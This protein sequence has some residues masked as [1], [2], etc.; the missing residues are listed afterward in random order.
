MRR[1][2]ASFQA[3]LASLSEQRS[4]A[5]LSSLGI[6]VGSVAILLLVSIAKGVQDDI[7]KEVEGLGVNLLI[8][9]P[10]RFEDNSML[11]PGLIGISHL[12]REDI[13]RIRGLSGVREAVPFS[14]VG[15]GLASGERR[16]P[17][18]M[19]VATQPEWF[20]MR[21][22]AFRE[23]RGI[24]PEERQAYVCVLGSL[25]AERLFPEGGAVGRTVSQSGREYKVVGVT[26]DPKGSSIF[27]QG[28]FENFAILP[29]ET[30]AALQEKAQINRIFIQTD[31]EKEPKQLVGAVERTLGQRL[32]REM[33]S[34]L[35]QEELLQLVYKVMSVLTTLLTGLT[36]IALFVGG[37]GIMTVMLMSVQ[38]RAREIGIR[39]TVGARRSDIFVQFLSEALL[40]SLVGAAAGIALSFGIT[41]AIARF[42]VIKPM[43]DF[44]VV[45]MALSVSILVGVLFG[46]VPA[47]RAAAKD[48][49]QAMRY[50]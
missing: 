31:P 36:S 37:V 19:V 50:E 18:A 46:L 28:S 45:A 23:G 42:T 13:S 43:L 34:V 16:S 9:L 11:A 6:M 21:K 47:M 14:F 1:V 48:P 35:T 27:S 25:V 5:A 30:V 2:L 26:E 33:Y 38:E 7:G 41:Q 44:P 40:L 15:S 17:A 12:E 22:A 39:K 4:R 49:V 3:S 29:F 10:G 8:V 32:D 24:L 20:A